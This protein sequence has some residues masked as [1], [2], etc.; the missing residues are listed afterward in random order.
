MG[1]DLGAG[2]GHVNG[3]GT[4]GL[5]R[6]HTHFPPEAGG[7]VAL[8]SSGSVRAGEGRAKARA[9]CPASPGRP[10]VVLPRQLGLLGLHQVL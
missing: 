5:R 6:P 3:S 7:C 9:A 10:S 8:P 1:C 2:W 4:P